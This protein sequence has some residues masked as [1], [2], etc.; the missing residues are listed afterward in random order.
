MVKITLESAKKV[1]ERNNCEEKKFFVTKTF[2]RRRNKEIIKY[3]FKNLIDNKLEYINN[4]KECFIYYYI[5]VIEDC[6]EQDDIEMVNFFCQKNMLQNKFYHVKS[7][8]M[9]KCIEK[10]QEIFTFNDF[11]I[12][13]FIDNNYQDILKYL[14]R[15][16][17]LK[18]TRTFSQ[19]IVDKNC[20]D[21]LE[22][23]F[24]E[25]INFEK[26][27]SYLNVSEEIFDIFL[28][29]SFF[30]DPYFDENKIYIK[31]H[32]VIEK[33]KIKGI[34]DKI[35]IGSFFGKMNIMIKYQ[36]DFN[37][38]CLLEN[39]NFFK[40]S[41]FW[42]FYYASCDSYVLKVEILLQKFGSFFPYYQ[43]D[44][45]QYL[46]LILPHI[47]KKYKQEEQDEIYNFMKT[48]TS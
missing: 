3:V 14:I 6:I 37:L 31:N 22:F 17:N 44:K 38:K 40:S 12:Y 8:E 21:I 16:Y 29:K 1:F 4:V 35:N 13:F 23:L 30:N 24:T 20:L 43:A 26:N 32:N 33:F 25:N 47:L 45:K 2:E 15:K 46:D 7:V 34:L 41:P 39:P 5:C 10:Y 27:I 48:F 9:I 18:I 42:F 36:E 11:S 19:Y 28:S